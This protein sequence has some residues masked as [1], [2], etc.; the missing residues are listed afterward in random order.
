[1]ARNSC[2]ASLLPRDLNRA[3]SSALEESVER[4][5]VIS[6]VVWIFFCP[7]RERAS[8]QDRSCGQTITLT[9]AKK[10]NRE[11]R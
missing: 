10:A 7:M 8:L 11:D 3:S 5:F 6:A 9:I 4:S 1:M 2:H